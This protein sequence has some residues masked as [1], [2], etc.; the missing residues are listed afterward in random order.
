VNPDTLAI[1][2]F[3]SDVVG[4]I[5]AK[6]NFNL[7]KELEQADRTRSMAESLE[8]HTAKA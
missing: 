8:K 7:G 1:L 5:K 2:D 4:R 3:E 6:P